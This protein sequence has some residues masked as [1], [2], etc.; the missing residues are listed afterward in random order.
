MD[1]VWQVWLNND[2]YYH[3]KVPGKGDSEAWKEAKI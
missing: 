1:K 2:S 3:E